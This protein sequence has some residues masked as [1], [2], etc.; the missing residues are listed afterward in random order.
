MP[1]RMTYTTALA[2]VR[3]R[4]DIEGDDHIADTELS[5]MMSA[6]Y[7]EV[8]QEVANSGH[9][10]WETTHTITADGS[11]SY[12]EPDDHLATIQLE[13]VD[14]SDRRYPLDEIMAQER[15]LYAGQSG[16]E[17]TL[18]CLVDDQIFLFPKPSSGTY[19]L[20]YIPQCPDLAT[21]AGSDLFDVV[22]PDGEELFLWGSAVKAL[23]KKSRDVRL[24]I[25]ER[26][27]A[28]ARL[29]QW[30]A[31]RAFNGPRRRIFVQDDYDPR[32][33]DPG[34]WRNR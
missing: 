24:A 25:A 20:T 16:G 29:Q 2:R 31:L 28:R 4:A 32:D 7:G 21:Y 14:A 11:D 12:D 22:T 18:W 9:R 3:Q 34:S 15:H 19:E 23:S 33:L 10:Y 13:R 30:A 6:A 1:R 26:E 27:A 5:A 8:Y 17:A